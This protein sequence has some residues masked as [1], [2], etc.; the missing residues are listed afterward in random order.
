MPGLYNIGV[1]GLQVAQMGLMATQHNVANANTP[2]YSRQT[3]VQ[4][5]NIPLLSSSGSVGQGVHVTTVQRMY[6]SFMADQVNTAQAS[7]SELKIFY[8]QISQINNM[9]ADDNAGLSPALQGFFRSVQQVAAN[10]SSVASR[11]S[12]VASSQVLVDRFQALDARLTELSSEVNGRIV[13]AVTQVNA[14]TSQIADLNQKIIV[15]QAAYGQPPNDLLDARDKLIGDL[16]KVLKVQTYPNQDGSVSVSISKGQQLVVG[17]LQTQ[18]NAAMSIADPTRMAVG[19]KT[20]GGNLELPESMIVG[21]ELG[22]LLSFRNNALDTTRDE[23]G[24]IAASFALTFNAQNGLGQDLYGNASG[25][26][27][28]VGNMFKLVTPTVVPGSNNI[29]P[30][31]GSVSAVLTPLGTATVPAQAATAPNPPTYSGNFSTNLQASNYQVNFG[32]AGAWNVTRIS[33]GQTV[34]SGVG[35]PAGAVTFDGVS[36]TI[37]AVGANGDTFLIQPVRYQAR[38]ISVDTRVA[39][40]ARLIAAAAPMKVDP[41]LSNQGTMKVAQGVAGL[42]YSM[43]SLPLTL[44]ATAATLGGFPA[45][46][47][48][49]IYTD[50]STVAAAGASVNLVNGAATLAGVTFNGMYFAMSGTPAVGD[51][52][53]ISTNSGGVQD[54]R[55]AVLL[56]KLATQNTTNGGSASYQG[57]YAQLVATN[58]IKTREASA[59]ND[60]QQALLDQATAT[61]EGY[62]GVNLDEEA[63]NLLKYQQAYQAAAKSIQIASTL[64]DSILAIGR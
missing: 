48:T 52:F 2:G 40:D 29:V 38:N 14:Y 35:V 12:M 8:D 51:T 47:A 27:N 57:T 23:M 54:G 17:S 10:P 33:D 53:A 36:M 28:F 16:N 61:R 31:T 25:N 11:Q 24:R 34:S 3:I 42:G 18:L 44:T 15:S 41:G 37:G 6:S 58:G 26:A 22:G 4:S 9:L 64:F 39:A 43:A 50:G 32:A 30:A 56:G 21:G 62:S 60:A 13:D 1:N 7:V 46:T 63:G 20:M 59:K 45:G 49:A 55:N 5:T 19:V